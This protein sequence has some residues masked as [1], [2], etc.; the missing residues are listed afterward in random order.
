MNKLKL[1]DRQVIDIEMCLFYALISYLLY[2]NKYYLGIVLLLLQIFQPS[3]HATRK[4]EK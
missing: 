1:R 2:I 4:V 3:P